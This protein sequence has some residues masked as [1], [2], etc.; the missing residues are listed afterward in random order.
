MLLYKII[1]SDV[2]YFSSRHHLTS[3]YLF[4]KLVNAS[5][6]Q[7]DLD[8]IFTHYDHKMHVLNWVTMLRRHCRNCHIFNYCGCHIIMAAIVIN[9]NIII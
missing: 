6:D 8:V 3:K 2:G 9:Y 7:N 4:I 5:F 1:P